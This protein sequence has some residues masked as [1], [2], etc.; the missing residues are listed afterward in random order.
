MAFKMASPYRHPDTGVYW[1]RKRAPAAVRAKV[2][3]TP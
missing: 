3:R 2:G 1:F